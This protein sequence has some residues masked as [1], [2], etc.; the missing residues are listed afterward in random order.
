MLVP[1]SFCR[2]YNGNERNIRNQSRFGCSADTEKVGING[3]QVSIRIENNESQDP[4]GNH[5]CV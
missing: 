2:R 4:E 3:V 5:I 1:F